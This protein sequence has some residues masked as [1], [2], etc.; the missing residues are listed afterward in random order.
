MHNRTAQNTR[1][2]PLSLELL[3]LTAGK[4]TTAGETMRIIVIA[5]RNAERPA[6]DFAKHSAAE[7]K[8]A[9]GFVADGILRE[10]Y[11]MADGSGAILIC[12]ADS[13]EAAQAELSKLPFCQNGLLNL[14]I[15]PVVGYRGFRMAVD[16]ELNR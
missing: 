16:G 6:E 7:V 12:E 11:S 10:I 1:V 5:R 3:W 9:F 8:T 4:P 13:A 2:L 14:E 15:I